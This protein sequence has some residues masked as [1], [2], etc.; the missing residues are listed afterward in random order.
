MP[1][2]PAPSSSTTEPSSECLI[3][4]FNVPHS[5]LHCVPACLCRCLTL[6]GAGESLQWTVTVDGQVSELSSTNYAPP[7]ITALSGLGAVNASVY[8]NQDVVITGNYFGPTA[9]TYGVKY[10]QHQLWNA[11][12]R[13]CG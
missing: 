13:C 7:V 10:G 6:P 4:S 12:A 2:I 8:G 5:S 11:C 9:D 1:L 3:C